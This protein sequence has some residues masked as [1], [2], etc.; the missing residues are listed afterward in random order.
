MDLLISALIIVVL[1]FLFVRSAQ[2]ED[3]IEN[4]LMVRKPSKKARYIKRMKRVR[5]CEWI[6]TFNP[7]FGRMSKKRPKQQTCDF[8]SYL[9]DEV[10]G[11][12]DAVFRQKSQ[13]IFAD[14]MK[15]SSAIFVSHS[16]GLLRNMCTMG[17]AL[18]QGQLN[19]FDDIEDAI[20]FH[21]ELM[22][23]K[24]EEEC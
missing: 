13:V 7:H 16:M 21:H 2:R 15:N 9:V 20:S 8:D 18:H 11:V 4:L 14:R 17:A 19:I 5:S 3:R 1:S 12:G 24:K 6:R 10:I 23:L 22:G